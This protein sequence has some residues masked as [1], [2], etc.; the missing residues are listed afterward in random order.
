MVQA[1]STSAPTNRLRRW[2]IL[3]TAQIS[4]E[5]MRAARLSRRSVL[6]AVASRND[7]KAREW[8]RRYGIPL[9]FGSYDEM[10][11]SGEID[12]VYNPLPNSL[13]AKWTL[14]ALE[15]G[16]SVLCEKPFTVNADEARAVQQVAVAKGLPVA[17]AFMY[18]H[19]PQ[20]QKVAELL[21]SGIIGEVSSLHGQFTFLL[22]DRT[23]NP[24]SVELAGG[25]LMDV[26]CYCVHFSRM[27]AGCEP[28]WASAFE[29][30]A[31]VDNLLVGLLEFPNGILSHFETSIA[32]FERHRAEIAGTAGS[33][34][35]TSPWVPGDK[36]ATIQIHRPETAPEEIIIPAANSYQLEVDDFVAVCAGTTSAR[37]PVA[38]AVANM[39]VLDALFSSARERRAIRIS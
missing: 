2:G 29:N 20:W 27:I 24:A 33:L 10:L 26:G 7:S 11:Q 8:A 12:L 3:G 21:Q 25:A 18:R 35:L 5:F 37:W 23:L 15:A 32:N 19:H 34:L 13:H 39:T 16:L 30:R 17:E 1:Q 14:R 38:D 28:T 4:T 22:D 31:G 36:P 6:R 9:A